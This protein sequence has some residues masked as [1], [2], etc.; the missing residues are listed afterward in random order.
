M[1]LDY[2][3]ELTLRLVGPLRLRRSDGVDVTPRTLK[4]QGL[5]ALLGTAPGLRKPRAWL[6]DKL[7]SDHPAENGAGSL[8][9]TVHRLRAAVGPDDAW[10]ISDAGWLGLDPARVSV[11]LEPDAA[12]W[13]ANGDPPEFCE[14]LDIADPEFEDWLRDRRFAFE[15]RMAA[16]G[17]PPAPTAPRLAPP[18]RPAKVT[19]LVAPIRAEDSVVGGLAEILSTEVAMAVGRLGGAEVLMEDRIST[20]PPAD[21]TRLEV[22]AH[23]QGGKAMMQARLTEN[24]ALLWT[25]TRAL[26]IGAASGGADKTLEAFI[27]EVTAATSHHIG[28]GGSGDGRSLIRAGYRALDNLFAVERDSLA[29]CEKIFAATTEGPAANIHRAWRAQIRTFA[30]IERLPADPKEAGREAMELIASALSADPF[31]PII[32]AIASDVAMHVEDNPVKAGHLARL[33]VERDIHSPHARTS[34]AQAQA[35]LGN[36]AHAHVEALRALRLA[37]P[38]PNQ[39]WWLMRCCVT[40]VRCHRFQEATRFAQTAHDMAPQSKPPLRFLA[41]LRFHARDEAATAQ[42]LA[43]LKALEPDFSLDL[44]EREDYPVTSLHGTPLIE[45]TRSGLL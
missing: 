24:G 27:A 7:W 31:N 37:A 17:A 11:V 40:A 44:M 23:R 32:C 4:A 35:W 30:I 22:T 29:D 2:T 39:S 41:A 10:L 8:R 33:A 12:D 42:A 26:S 13:E 38:L 43:R 19:L 45:V 15:D 25:N 16:C 18:P 3:P 36:A 34:A 14:G 9:Q 28:R 21:A 1:S 6:Q 5:L 20:A